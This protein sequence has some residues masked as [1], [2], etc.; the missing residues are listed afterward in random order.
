MSDDLQRI[1]QNVQSMRDQGAPDADVDQYLKEEGTD[2]K[3]I[4]RAINTRGASLGVPPEQY[5]EVTGTISALAKG[6][7]FNFSDEI[8]GILA[9]GVD[10]AMGASGNISD[11]YRARQ[12]VYEDAD[13]EFQKAH[14]GL[15]LGAQL[16]G[17]TATALAGG[18]LGLVKEGATAL[19]AGD[20]AGLIAASAKGSLGGAA[21]GAVAGAGDAE[22]GDITGGAERGAAGGAVLG[23]VL[24]PAGRLISGVGSLANKI[25]GVSA[26]TGAVRD[27]AGD[28]VDNLRQLG[29]DITTLRGGTPSTPAPMRPN[30]SA[31]DEKILQ[32]MQRDGKDPA[33]VAAQMAQEANTTGGARA[34]LVDYGG[35]NVQGLARAGNTLAGEARATY[36]RVLQQRADGQADRVVGDALDGLAVP[37]AVDADALAAGIAE[38]R[39]ADAKPAYDKAFAVGPVED[40]EVTQQLIGP[41]SQA[42]QKAHEAA[43]ATFNETEGGSISPLFDD[44]GNL[45]RTPTVRDLDLIKRGVDDR[46]FSNKTGQAITPAS[47]L[48]AQG[49]LALKGAV[50]GKDGLMAAVD[51]AVPE[52]AAARAQYAS[53]S[54]IM[55]AL[56]QGRELAKMT[57]GQVST[58]VGQLSDPASLAAF[59]VGVA[60]GIRSQVAKLSDV[61]SA[62]RVVNAIFGSP[63]KRDALQPAFPSQ[64]AYDKFVAQMGVEAKMNATSNF[65]RGG[66]QTAN[67][68]AEVGDSLVTNAGEALA[69]GGLT[70]L[71]AH[72][73]R[74]TMAEL[75]GSAQEKM[76]AEIA[77]KLTQSHGPALTAYLQNLSRVSAARAAAAQARAAGAQGVNGTLGTKRP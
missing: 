71:A 72:G 50:Y 53:H 65:I 15:S 29:S 70:G 63:A 38:K 64:A 48:D 33:A 55:D 28:V 7:T 5:N 42:F 54:Q 43:R 76:G 44:E 34:S 74:S 69:K 9:A 35:P 12:Q 59:R 27:Y 68:A 39:A 21:Y 37:K 51:Q 1:T 32:A 73:A 26:V 23:A 56:T 14:P 36:D 41:A 13:K 49:Q 25:P 67:K 62:P 10:K 3:T 2:A 11:L 77:D 18:G 19:Q 16:I 61:N 75:L 6:A 8:R 52:Y 66:S 58:Y 17:G 31:A 20:K 22:P 4:Q 46:I 60:D 47:K 45:L 57:P 30:M 40:D 24:P